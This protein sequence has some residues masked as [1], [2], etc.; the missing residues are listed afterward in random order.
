MQNWFSGSYFKRRV[1]R[2]YSLQERRICSR[3]LI[4]GSLPPSW[5][6]TPR[7]V[8]NTEPWPLKDQQEKVL[9]RRDRYQRKKA[10]TARTQKGSCLHF[11]QWQ[12]WTGRPESNAE[13][14]KPTDTEIQTEEIAKDISHLCIELNS[15]F[16]M[17]L[18][19]KKDI[20]VMKPFTKSSLQGNSSGFIQHY[21]GLQTSKLQKQLVTSKRSLLI[22]HKESLHTTQS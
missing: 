7:M 12:Q 15:A 18:T 4:Y 17:I 9:V 11:S 22:P 3:H 21:T 6:V 1:D 8:T 10:R 14:I 2:E 13:N 20:E 19:L 5:T 16:A